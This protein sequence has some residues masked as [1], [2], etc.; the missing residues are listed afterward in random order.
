MSLSNRARMLNQQ[1]TTFALERASGALGLL[2]EA[3]RGDA[4]HLLTLAT[5]FWS[6]TEPLPPTERKSLLI[7]GARLAEILARRSAHAM[8]YAAL[9]RA[10]LSDA[11]EDPRTAETLLQEFETKLSLLGL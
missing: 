9:A 10:L 5:E 6:G 11:R 3:E 2:P 1:L 4:E 7:E 8:P